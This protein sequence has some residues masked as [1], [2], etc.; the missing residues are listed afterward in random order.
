LIIS[1]LVLALFVEPVFPVSWVV[2]VMS[3]VHR[4][5]TS[6]TMQAART[7]DRTDV[8]AAV[9]FV[10]RASLTFFQNLRAS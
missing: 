2:E 10:A 4:E 5:L 3:S 7:L 9:N 8:Q 1:F 6:L